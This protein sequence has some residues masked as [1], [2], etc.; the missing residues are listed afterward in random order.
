MN[1]LNDSDVSIDIPRIVVAGT[2]SGVGKTTIVLA[3]TQALQKRGLAVATFKCGPDYLDPTYHARATGKT[4]HN[5]DGWLM[6]KE[7]VLN[8][9]HQACHNAD[10]A[11]IEGVMGLFD[12]HSPNSEAGSTA[13]IA[14]W[15]NAPVIAVVDAG[16][17]ARTVSAIL[18]GL[19]A[20]DPELRIAGAFTNFI[21][22][23]SHIQLLKDASNEV[24][25]LGGFSKHPEQSFPER[26]LGLYSASEENLSE[27]R[28]HF[29]GNL[30]EEWLEIDSVLKIADSA[31][32]IN[33]PAPSRKSDATR[34]RIGVALDNAFHFY[35]EENLM[36]LKEAGAE[37]IFFSPIA[38]SKI[39]DVD[40]LY[41]GGGY[42]EL[43]A[44][45]LCS[46]SPMLS[47]I[48]KF[49]YNNKPIYAECGGLMYLSD[50]IERVNGEIFSMLGLIPGK[51]KMGEK[52]KALGYVEVVTETK[53]IFGEAGLRFRGH[54]FRYSD[55]EP[56]TS[57]SQ[58]FEFAY[59][60]RR[61][62]GNEVTEE[63]YQTRSILASYVHVHWASNPTLPQGFVQS[64]SEARR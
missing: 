11:I 45:S 35:Y 44:E 9:F 50:E 32:K 42:P 37:L 25:I 6:G 58:G 18:K 60:L 28:F 22:S 53:T 52:L 48:R 63:G 59:K 31:P 55:F 26:H 62:R 13:E 5:L 40:G 17:M 23:K 46:N 30:G 7:S 39:P 41:F 21:G 36:R 3:I 56:K 47:D 2:G 54:Q 34:C 4:C 12:G 49:A 64:C 43:F 19:N 14:K 51:V 10:I 57:A 15:L 27:D 1:V 20:F 33:V 29:W 8:T 61:R 24:P 16:G 38:D